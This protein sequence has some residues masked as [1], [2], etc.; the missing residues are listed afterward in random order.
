MTR[1]LHAFSI[2][3]PDYDAALAFYVDTLGFELRADIPL[4][5][6]KR[7]V[8]IAPDIDAQTNILLARADGET[9]IN[10]VGNQFGGRVGLFLHTDSFERDYNAMRAK[11]V[12][13][14]E[15]PRHEPYGSVAVWQDPFGNRWDLLQLN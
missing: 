7:W 15:L 14:E 8:L 3:V 13:F 9:Q 1:H 4:E 10:A 5:D 2:V 11:G 6:G 12:M